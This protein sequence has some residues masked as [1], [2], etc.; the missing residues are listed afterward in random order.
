MVGFPPLIQGSSWRL[1]NFVSYLFYPSAL[2]FFVLYIQY[3]APPK[4]S[5]P[6]TYISLV[7][8]GSRVV[9]N[10]N[11]ETQDVSLGDGKRQE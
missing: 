5:S 2:I 3:A 11:F 6:S 7:C 10:Q 1:Y 9:L 4:Y 8:V